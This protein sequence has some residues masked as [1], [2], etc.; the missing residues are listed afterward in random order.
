VQA[1]SGLAECMVLVGPEHVAGIR[2]W[3]K[4]HPTTAHLSFV[5]VAEP[6]W[7]PL[8]KWHRIAWFSVYLFWLRQAYR[9]GLRLHRARAFDVIC[10]AS[11][12]TYWL[13]SPAVRFGVPS[14]WG[15][16]GGA[17]TTPFR[18]WPL[19][20]WRGI[21]GELLDLTAVRMLA[22]LPA[23]RRTWRNATVRVVQNQ[24]TLAR[25]PKEL[26]SSTRILNHA[27]FADTRE[28]RRSQPTA[29]ILFI[30]SLAPRK[31]ARLAVHALAYACEDVH[32]EVIGDGPERMKLGRLARRLRVARRVRFAGQLR[33]EEVLRKLEGASAVVFTGLREEGGIALAEAMRAGVPVIVLAHGGARTIAES[34]VDPS[35]VALIEPQNVSVMARRIGEAMTRF[36]RPL[37]FATGGTLDVAA[38]LQALRKAF[39]AALAA[40]GSVPGTGR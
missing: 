18:L 16:V 15:P 33:R 35:R 29:G 36:T 7:A 25:L 17:V 37:P 12:S 31:G 1:L 23:T 6:R 13:P 20:G 27:F 28:A 4:S 22:R 2:E 21:I 10:H 9:V 30:G 5:E 14:I 19:L 40:S 38:A 8:S 24:E 3:E 11:Y 32:L 39:E 34:A 26:Q